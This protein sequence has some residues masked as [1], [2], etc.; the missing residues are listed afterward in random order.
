[1]NRTYKSVFAEDILKNKVLMIGSILVA[2]LAFGFAVT[3]FSIGVDDP[4]A[5]HYL[6]TL[7]W[8]NMLQQGRLLHILFDRLTGQ[9]TFIPFLNDF[10]GAGL[11]WLS[12]VLFCGLFQYVTNSRL[13]TLSLL[14]FCGVYL[15]YP[16]TAEKFI[17][18]LDTI[19]TM[20]SYVCVAYSLIKAY[21][22]VYYKKKLSFL[23]SLGALVLG[24]GAYE[25]FIFLYI[26]GVFA[27]FILKCVVAEEKVT[28]KDAFV[29]GLQFLLILVLA[30]VLY[31]GA[32]YV[33]QVYKDQVGLF[34]R[35]SVWNAAELDVKQTL[36]MIYNR[37]LQTA[38]SGKFISVT[39]FL[40]FTGVGAALSLVY[41]VKRKSIVLPLC[42]LGLFAANLGIHIVVG[43]VMLRGAQTLCFFAGL[44]ALLVV[45]CC[46]AEKFTWVKYGV[47]A[48]ACLLVFV[49]LAELNSAF[50]DD[51]ARYKK[52]EF[53]VHTIATR[54]AAEC[55]VS[56]PVVFINRGTGYLNSSLEDREVIGNAMMYWGVHTFGEEQSPIMLE[57]FAMHGYNFL[58]L[59]DAE[60]VAKAKEHAAEMGAWPA[61][62]CIKEF[63]D[64]IVV[65]MGAPEA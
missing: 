25:S 9:L 5:H 46:K 20:F 32:V 7:G 12:G 56:K 6:H 65:S 51:Y 3:N 63:D 30:F 33:L 11:F 52:E 18:N 59:P 62:D 47:S 58:V 34:E 23:L 35:A 50:Y 43:F 61:Q 49:Q 1:M 22:F 36:T 40:I 24:L 27:I 55:D 41:A 10:I 26:C 57:I 39:E 37:L 4:A 13:H 42:F 64:Y 16:V 53:V 17:Y 54:L 28:L 8:G 2:I 44:V 15:S 48:V 60:T 31:Y 14:V 19:V 21:E 38:K 29:K 45:Y